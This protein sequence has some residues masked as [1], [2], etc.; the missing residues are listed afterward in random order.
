MRDDPGVT[1]GRVGGVLEEAGDNLR[2]GRRR[3]GV[4]VDVG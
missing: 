2:V 3:D 1:A 4:P